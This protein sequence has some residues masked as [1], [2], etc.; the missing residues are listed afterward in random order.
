VALVRAA[1]QYSLVDSKKNIQAEGLPEPQ[2][3]SLPG[4]MGV[5]P[6]F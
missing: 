1:S 6:H 4:L 3:M 2:A 5:S